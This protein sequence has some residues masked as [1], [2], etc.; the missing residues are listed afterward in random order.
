MHAV[1]LLP[2]CLPFS[3][4]LFFI[5]CFVLVSF[6]IFLRLPMTSMDLARS[7]I[8]SQSNKIH[9]HSEVCHKMRPIAGLFQ[10][11]VVV[12]ADDGDGVRN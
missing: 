5:F 12:V 6:H 2:T 11:V 7:S 9:K 4:F 10:L 8:T 3:I 1:I